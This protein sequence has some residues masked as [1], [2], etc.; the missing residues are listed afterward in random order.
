MNMRV[1]DEVNSHPGV[2]GSLQIG[3]DVTDRIN[4]RTR[5]LAAAAEKVRNANGAI[6][7]ELTQDH[8]LAL[9][10]QRT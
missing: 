7:Q 2:V 9:L 6:V 8:G 5:G 10:Y 1:D 3:L 4:H